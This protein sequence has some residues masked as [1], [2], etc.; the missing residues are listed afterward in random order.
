M[1]AM[2]VGAIG[3][4]LVLEGLLYAVSPARLKQMAAIILR[5][6]DDQL[7]A[8][9]L[10]AIGAGVLIVYFARVVLAG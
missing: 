1:T 3:F 4:V 6:D 8:G 2:I 10:F 5:M 9:G 7:R